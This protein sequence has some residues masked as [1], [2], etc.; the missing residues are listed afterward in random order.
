MLDAELAATLAKEDHPGVVEAAPPA[1]RKKMG[2]FF[3]CCIGWLALLAIVTIFAPVLHLQ[4]P[5]A[6]QYTSTA[7]FG[8]NETPS[9]HHL[10]GTDQ[11]ARDLFSRVIWGARLS[12]EISLLAT[13]IGIGVGG[14]LG[15]L[16]AYL[17]GVVDAA[18]SWFMYCGL[19]FPAILAVL[20]ILAFWGRS[21]THIV[22]VIGGFSIPLIYRLVRAATLS[23]ASK[24]YIVAARSQGATALRV[25]L[26][27]ILPNV[28]PSLIVYTVFTIGG[29][30]TVEAALG[31]LGVGVQ[32][33]TP[34]WGN[35]LN[36]ATGDPSNISFVMSPAIALFLTL[37][38]LNYAGERIRSRFD[39][40]ES[41]L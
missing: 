5:T 18:L 27:D 15:M 21:S 20:A 8:I 28:L 11:L 30:I 37:V 34:T 3:W 41:K 40:V 14:L 29:V 17:G 33:P 35:I 1:P 26:K 6:Q 2:I 24:E 19:A 4:N 31:V 7:P 39:T 32:L 36:E 22:I 10:L 38:S 9:W 16:S 23:C 25:L 13:A 12:L